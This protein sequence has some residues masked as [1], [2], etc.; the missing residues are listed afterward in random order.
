MVAPARP[1][2]Q[3]VESLPKAIDFAH[4]T[5]RASDL[6]SSKFPSSQSEGDL[7]WVLRWA[8]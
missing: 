7:L 3:K 5:R 4:G 1:R 6:T 8:W 2:P